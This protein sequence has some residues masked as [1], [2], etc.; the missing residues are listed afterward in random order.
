MTVTEGNSGTANATFTVSLSAASGQTVTVNYATADGTAVAPGDY[1][2]GSG[3]L[4]F[5][6]GVTTQTIT[7]PVNGDTL[8]EANE[9][10]FVNLS[11]PSQRHDPG[12]PGPGH[13]HQRRRRVPSLSIGDVTVTEG[14]SGTVERRVHRD[15]VARPAARPSR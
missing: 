9:T 15:P 6:P 1:T 5:T 11:G 12:R 8:G 10:F 3:T 14:N 13:H 4:T 7:V 2:A